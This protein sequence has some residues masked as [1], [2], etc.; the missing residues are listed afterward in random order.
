MELWALSWPSAPAEGC[1][2]VP[3]AGSHAPNLP[4]LGRDSVFGRKHSL[5]WGFPKQLPVTGSSE[6]PAPPLHSGSV[7][8]RGA[9]KVFL[10]V[11]P[12]LILSSSS[13]PA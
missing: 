5:A 3:A 7:L 4:A 8:V 10:K 11:S 2:F 6:A 1:W 13:R 12:F 9:T